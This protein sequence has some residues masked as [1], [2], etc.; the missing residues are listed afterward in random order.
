MKKHFLRGLLAVYAASTLLFTA[1]MPDISAQNPSARDFSFSATD[2]G[3][4]CISSV[5]PGAVAGLADSRDNEAPG[6]AAGTHGSAGGTAEGGA[7]GSADEKADGQSDGQADMSKIVASQNDDKPEP[8]VFGDEPAVLILHTHAT[9]TYLPSD[10]GNYHSKKKE[11]SVRDVGEVLAKSLEEEGIAVVH[12]LTLHDNPSYSSSYSRSAETVKI[13][14]E[15]YPTIRC[16][17]DLHRDA[18]AS[19]APG[20]T[21]SVGGKTC[22][23]YMY[24]VSTAVPNY[25]ANLKLISAMNDIAAEKYSGFTGTVLERGY[26]YNQSLADRYLLVEFGNNRNDITDVR[27]TARIWGK[28]LAQ[29]LKEGY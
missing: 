21:L 18:T 22:A 13:L 14:L 17:I 28:I 16:V 25:K 29:A 20:A 19:D 24:V 5:Y 4:L 15:K 7:N 8:V 6:D 9:E 12:D 2:F 27:N 3:V 23:R 26:P 10:E 1:F 11:N